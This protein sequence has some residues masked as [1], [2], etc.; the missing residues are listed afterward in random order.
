MARG[1][2]R[3]YSC[4]E[5]SDVFT[6]FRSDASY[7]GPKCRKRASRAKKRAKGSMRAAWDRM[8]P[9]ERQDV[10]D[11]GNVRMYLREDNA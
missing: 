3:E 9:Q 11:R 7:C 4:P 10:I 8:L 6:A 1:E 2:E 5:C